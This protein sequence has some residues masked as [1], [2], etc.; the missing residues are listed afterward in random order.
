MTCYIIL[1]CIIFVFHSEFSIGD[2]CAVADWFIFLRRPSFVLDGHR[3]GTCSVLPRDDAQSEFSTP[4]CHVPNVVTS[5]LWYASF[6][7]RGSIQPS[8]YLGQRHP[9]RPPPL[10]PPGH[11]T[12]AQRRSGTAETPRICS[13]SLLSH[14]PSL[15]VAP[16]PSSGCLHW[17]HCQGSVSLV[18]GIQ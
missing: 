12:T 5:C 8:P 9:L 15:V 10:R 18:H 13:L 1:C 3:A 6:L 4:V 2:S 16:P 14:P 7:F 17:H 11:C